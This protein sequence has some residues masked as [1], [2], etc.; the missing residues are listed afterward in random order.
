VDI[1]E[2][3]SAS[4]E[5]SMCDG[6]LDSGGLNTLGLTSLL[7]D[8]KVFFMWHVGRHQGYVLT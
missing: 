5:V 7:T 2:T 8:D 4:S 3:S 6:L 1:V